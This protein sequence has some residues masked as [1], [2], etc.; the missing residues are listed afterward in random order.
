MDNIILT[1]GHAGL[2]R[3]IERT[4]PE[5]VVTVMQGDPPQYV[6]DGGLWCFVDWIPADTSGLE[7]CRSLRAGRTTAH[8]HITMV[9]DDD[10]P[11]ARRRA[12]DAGADDYMLG[13]LSAARL[14]E[15]IA[16]YRSRPNGAVHAPQPGG[17]I[18][19]TVNRASRQVRWNGRLVPLRPREFELLA[20]FVEQPD[21]L[22]TREQIIALLDDNKEVCDKRT[23]DVWV[24]R[25]RRALERGG[26]PPMLRTVRSIGYVLDTPEVA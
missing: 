10:D 3:Q 4:L 8:G 11:A 16:R 15:R 19:L 23:V 20:H 18:G 22:F 17:H 25:L 5:C 26:A 6:A 13:P 7:V 14:A 24:G 1:S 12:L 9:L 21:R 2:L